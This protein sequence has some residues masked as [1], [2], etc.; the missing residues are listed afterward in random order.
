MMA[1]RKEQFWGFMVVNENILDCVL[2]GFCLFFFTT[3]TT[4]PS[5]KYT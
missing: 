3:V 2:A 5:Y 1:E 4:L